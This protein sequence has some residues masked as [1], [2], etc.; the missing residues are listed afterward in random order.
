MSRYIHNGA[1]LIAIITNDGWWGNTPGYHQHENY[2][3]LRAIETRRWIVRSANTGVSCVI[4]PDGNII[5]PQP[6]VQAAAIK[7]A[8]PAL[9]S[10][11][12]IYVRYGDLLSK[13]ALLLAILF[14][15]WNIVTILKTRNSRG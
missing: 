15:C 3:R 1:D 4:D 8:V 13:A 12:T 14:L 6:W 2:A 11:L 10:K 9:N 7:Q 5:D